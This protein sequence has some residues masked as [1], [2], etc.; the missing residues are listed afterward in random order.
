MRGGRLHG[1]PIL[2]LL[3]FADGFAKAVP[4]PLSREM[5]VFLKIVPP[6]WQ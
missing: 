1:E 3:A 5:S 6:K 2:V 4:D